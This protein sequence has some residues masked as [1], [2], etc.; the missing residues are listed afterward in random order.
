MNITVFIIQATTISTQ[1][2]TI[3]IQPTDVPPKQAVPMQR[4]ASII[5]PGMATPKN[6][7]VNISNIIGAVHPT[8]KY[9]TTMNARTIGGA[10]Q[11]IVAQGT[12]IHI[13]GDIHIDGNIIAQTNS[14]R[15]IN[16]DRHIEIN[17][18]FTGSKQHDAAIHGRQTK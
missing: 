1:D 16:I 7:I 9:I 14:D 18:T 17:A 10:L 8:R 5:F 2:I 3:S 15:H 12:I 13:S 11:R 4:H 6:I